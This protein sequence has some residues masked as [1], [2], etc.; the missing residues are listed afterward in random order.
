VI[1]GVRELNGKETD[2]VIIDLFYMFDGMV[3]TTLLVIALRLITALIHSY[4]EI[5]E[6]H[7]MMKMHL[8]FFVL[9]EAVVLTDAMY[10]ICWDRGYVN[11]SWEND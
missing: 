4:P 10:K 7:S 2:S 5:K 1:V 8:I 6:S 11:L 3:I 9:N